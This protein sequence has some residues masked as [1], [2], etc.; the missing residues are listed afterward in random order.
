MGDIISDGMTKVTWVLTIADP[1]APTAT[2]LNAGVS[3]EALITPDGYNITQTVDRV[4]AGS[5]ASTQDA[6]LIGRTKS[7]GSLTFKHQGDDNPP[8]T[9]FAKVSN[10]YPRGFL[11]TRFG[12]PAIQPFAADD[13]V[14][15]LPVEGIRG[16]LPSAK[17]E[18]MK[19]TVEISSTGDRQESVAVV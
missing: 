17:N 16:R 2:I 4:D 14:D 18:V 5:L 9:T 1:A 11:V 6:E 7:G 8:W 19:F 12:V 3:L 10:A 13:S 15:V